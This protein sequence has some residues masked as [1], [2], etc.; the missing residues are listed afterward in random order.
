VATSFSASITFP[1]DAA[2]AYALLTDPAYVE[3]VARGTGGHD[4][5]ISV[6]PTDDGGATVASTRDLP[7]QVPSYAKPL[8]G[9]TLTIAETRVFGPQAEDGSRDGTLEV[10]FPGAP[11]HITG[12]LR[13]APDGDGSTI[14]VHAQ[15]R[16]SVPLVGGKVER[17]AAEQMGRAMAKEQTI[18]DARFG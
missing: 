7:A 6:H 13:L 9:D 8:V 14:E 15:V 1:T 2:S 10:G 11:L 3:D 4:P 16:A 12:T 17:F 18:V 5:E